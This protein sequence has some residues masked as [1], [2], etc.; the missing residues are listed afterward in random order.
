[1]APTSTPTTLAATLRIGN[2]WSI[3]CIQLSD[4][5]AIFGDNQYHTQTV[6]FQMKYTIEF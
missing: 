4:M 6:G 2:A 1:V 3:A 5:L